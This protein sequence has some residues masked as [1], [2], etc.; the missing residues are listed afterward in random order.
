MIQQLCNINNEGYVDTF[1]KVAIF[2]ASQLPYFS[3][4]T[5][6]DTVENLITNL[7]DSAQVLLTD[8]LPGNLQLNHGSRFSKDGTL[9]STNASFLI[10]PQDKN[11]QA[12][13]E[14]Y[15]NKEVVI[16][17]SKRTTSHLYGTKI[18]PLLFG[19][20]EANASTPDIIKGYNI[21]INGEGYGASKLFEEVVFNIFSRGLAF[22]LAQQI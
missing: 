11:L 18:Q 20:S 5:A 21:T 10:T 17:I 8:L 2:E 6:D 1:F 15:N 14:T 12:L 22:K 19:Y 3:H 7:P 16:L 13:L 9:Y 4:L